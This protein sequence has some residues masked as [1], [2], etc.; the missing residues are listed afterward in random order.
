MLFSGTRIPISA[1]SP[2]PCCP[3]VMY[4]GSTGCTVR[5]MVP[6]FTP[7]MFGNSW[8]IWFMTWCVM[9]QCIAQ[10]PGLSAVNSTVRVDPTGTSTVVSGQR[11]A[12]GMTPPS[13][14]VTVK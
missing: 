10:S 13:V 12:S 4:S 14:S 6:G 2:M 3:I 7:I 9:W 1:M 11:P 5:S 8:P